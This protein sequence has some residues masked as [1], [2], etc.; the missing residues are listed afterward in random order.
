MIQVHEDAEFA[1]TAEAV[2]KTVGD[3]RRFIEAVGADAVFEGEGIGTL[4]TISSPRGDLVERLD[5]VDN[6]SRTL[7]YAVLDPSPLPVKNYLATLHVVAVGADRSKVEWE[8]K[9]EAADDVPEEKALRVI[10]RTFQG[11]LDRLAKAVES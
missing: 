2:W 4:R 1:A 3:F 5:A 6:D 7:T 9:F 11:G 10:S 8:A